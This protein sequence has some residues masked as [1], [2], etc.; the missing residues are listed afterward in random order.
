MKDM[1]YT[2]ES[3]VLF[4]E[5]MMEIC[6][7]QVNRDHPLLD[8][9]DIEGIVYSMKQRLLAGEHLV[10][11]CK[12]EDSPVDDYVKAINRWDRS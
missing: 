2:T 11:V 6:T 1:N 4:L 12:K 8:G 3:L 9:H 7:A 5:R 10:D